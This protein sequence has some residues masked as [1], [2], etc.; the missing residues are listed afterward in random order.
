L[1]RRIKVEVAKCLRR[2]A[3]KRYTR[4]RRPTVR[5]SQSNSGSVGVSKILKSGIENSAIQSM[6]LLFRRATCV[7]YTSWSRCT[8]RVIRGKGSGGCRIYVIS[9][10]RHRQ[11]IMRQ[12]YGPHSAT[13]F[14]SGHIADCAYPWRQTRHSAF[15]P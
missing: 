15:M 8:G 14:I 4:G 2:L 7:L 13:S 3:K 10:I 11:M 6:S 5:L 1:R 9:L 12:S